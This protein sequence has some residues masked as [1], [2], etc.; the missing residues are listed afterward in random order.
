MAYIKYHAPY[1]NRELRL[2]LRER[3]RI[4]QHLR[5]HKKRNNK[6]KEKELLK[7]FIKVSDLIKIM[8]TKCDK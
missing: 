4:K 8:C 7:R 3:L 1:R 5:Y 6:E 2:L